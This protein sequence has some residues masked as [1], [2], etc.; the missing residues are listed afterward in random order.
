MVS[1]HSRFY[2]SL[3]C[4]LFGTCASFSIPALPDI[5][6]LPG[7]PSLILNT[8]VKIAEKLD[9]MKAA[10]KVISTTLSKPEA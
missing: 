5:K 4:A 10:S 1:S 6:T 3:L 2:W 8:N 7:D 9:F